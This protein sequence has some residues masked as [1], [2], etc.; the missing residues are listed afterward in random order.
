MRNTTKFNHHSKSNNNNKPIKTQQHKPRNKIDGSKV[1]GS[2]K[3]RK[4]RDL[5]ISNKV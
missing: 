5:Q 1:N 3:P 4:L 2:T